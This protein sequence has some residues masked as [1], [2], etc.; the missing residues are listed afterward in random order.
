MGINLMGNNMVKNQAYEIENDISKQNDIRSYKTG[1]VNRIEWV[2]I[3]KFLAITIV[4]WLHFGAPDKA[5][6][7]FH[8]YHMPVFYFLSGYC[9]NEERNKLF[10]PFIIK[11]LKTLIIP[12]FLV[13]ILF[14]LYWSVIHQLLIQERVV[15]IKT[16]LYQLTTINTNVNS[17]LWGGI[18]W[19]LTSLFF[20]ELIYFI[21]IKLCYNENIR[22]ATCIIICILSLFTILS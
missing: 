8:L 17:Y 9:F 21:L 3:C 12:Y 20:T 19:F 5:D 22:F 14:Y 11:R 10:R 18:Q 15:S 6:N 2:D 16:F 7:Y 1:T 4:V 13:A